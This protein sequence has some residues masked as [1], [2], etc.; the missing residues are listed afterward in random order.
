MYFALIQ[1]GFYEDRKTVDLPK[2]IDENSYLSWFINNHLLDEDVKTITLFKEDR[3]TEDRHFDEVFDPIDE[4]V[5]VTTSTNPTPFWMQAPSGD[6]EQL[7]KNERRI[8]QN[9]I[10]CYRL[11][12]DLSEYKNGTPRNVD[13]RDA[14][15]VIRYEYCGENGKEWTGDDLAARFQKVR[16]TLPDDVVFHSFYDKHQNITAYHANKF[17]PFEM[18]GVEILEEYKLRRRRSD[19]YSLW[20][21]DDEFRARFQEFTE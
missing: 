1:N 6:W 8:G 17:G 11:I 7:P 10:V 5:L 16:V 9:I 15:N 2:D 14:N 20:M 19:D 3:T 21:T 13:I 18:E 4:C 12:T